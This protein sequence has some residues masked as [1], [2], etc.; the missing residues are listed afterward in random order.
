M[1][2]GFL[3]FNKNPIPTT[4]LH[5][6]VVKKFAKWRSPLLGENQLKTL[7][8]LPREQMISRFQ[9]LERWTQENSKTENDDADFISLHTWRALGEKQAQEF[10]ESMDQDIYIGFLK[11]LANDGTKDEKYRTPWSNEKTPPAFELP[12][13]RALFDELLDEMSAAEIRMVKLVLRGPQSLN[14]YWLWYKFIVH[15][16]ELDETNPWAWLDMNPPQDNTPPNANI[17]PGPIMQD[18]IPPRSPY[19]DRDYKAFVNKN[20]F[21]ERRARSNKPPDV[22]QPEEEG[23]DLEP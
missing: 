14:D 9:R 11:W 15:W 8:L 4:I 20:N 19:I 12:E 23:P 22:P 1:R 5:D 7:Q 10:V 6:D 21:S 2:R 18:A 3:S 17:V 13:V 16:N